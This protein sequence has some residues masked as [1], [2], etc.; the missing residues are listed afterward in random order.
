MAR[1]FRL[2][3]D[4]GSRGNPGVAGYGAVLSENGKI[5]AELYDFIGIETNNVAEYNGL[6]AG[7]RKVHELDPAARVEVEMDSKLVIEQMSGRW[8]I[9]HPGMR[10]LAL[11]CR[12]AHDPSLVTYRWI[13]RD[14]NSHADRL[15]NKAM[16]G[17]SGTSIETRVQKNYLTQRLRGGDTP[18][19]IY[20]VRHG[21][22]PLTP[23]RKF[24][25][26]GGA[27]PSLTEEGE[28]QARAVA[29]EISKIAPDVLISSPL[30]RAQETAKAIAQ[31][32]GLEILIDEIWTEMSFGYWDGLSFD[33][34]AERYP[35]EL[36]GWL[37]S[38][39]YRPAGGESYEEAM[40][41]VEEGLEKVVAE[42]PE[43]R[44][45]IVTHN[46]VIKVAA[47]LAL[48]A[49]IDSVF[50]I[51]AGPCSI[52]SISIWPTDGLRALRSLNERG[53]QR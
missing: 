36:Q 14:Q 51:D 15:A 35:D 13:P 19:W 4:G 34:V 49:Q 37:N 32:T 18:T 25:G 1:I 26:S 17:Q 45:C 46:G 43:K 53:H 42:Y 27:D 29:H 10:D 44:V 20:F 12:D 6:L 47:L 11:K 41:R 5:I 52:T 22:T 31:S 39:A 8:Q 2:S 24:S 33:E 50:H 23:D 21:E 9:K 30:M 7:L 16:D 28:K 3:A 48:G 38:A 40:V